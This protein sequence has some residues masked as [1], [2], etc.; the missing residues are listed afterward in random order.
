MSEVLSVSSMPTEGP[1]QHRL[2]QNHIQVASTHILETFDTLSSAK[3]DETLAS[4]LSPA[5]NLLRK[6]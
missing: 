6:C 1:H 4:R 5:G 3:G 2:C